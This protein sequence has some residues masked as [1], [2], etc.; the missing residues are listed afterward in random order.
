M[1]EY[2]ELLERLRSMIGD[3]FERYQHL[4]TSLGRDRTAIGATRR[5]VDR[6]SASGGTDR[7]RS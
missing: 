3:D 1:T 2:A 6:S 5:T 7:S 4:Q